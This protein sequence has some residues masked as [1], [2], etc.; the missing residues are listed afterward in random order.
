VTGLRR[1][2]AR[3]ETG[4]RGR[5]SRE[6]DESKD[7]KRSCARGMNVDVAADDDGGDVQ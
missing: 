3:Q 2:T 1:K 4:G 6:G 5:K 7:E